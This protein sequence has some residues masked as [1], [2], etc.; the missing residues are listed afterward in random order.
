[1]VT[2]R[3]PISRQVA[4]GQL[5]EGGARNEVN[6]GDLERWLSVAGGSLLALFGL[7]RADALGLGLAAAGGGLLFRGLTGHCHVYGA[8]GVNTG[9]KHGRAASIR[10]GEGVK[11]VQAVTIHR[12]PEDL[13]AAWRN[14][15]RL[16]QFMMHLVSVKTEGNRSHWVARAPAGMTIDWEAE[17]VNDEPNRLI[18]W[19]SLHGSRVSTAG[20]VTFT[21]APDGRGT[22]V[23]VTLKYDPPAGKLGSWLAWLFGEEP[24]VQV[25]DD[26]SRFKLLMEAGEIAANQG[27]RTANPVPVF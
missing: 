13:Y 19:R 18:A 11:V 26:L 7:R 17:I 21:P 14:F 9:E 12:S 6:V 23:R 15:E 10:A 24:S 16:P 22:E 5:R 4:S 27:V 3:T 20:T 1:M 25:R 8:L 2:Q